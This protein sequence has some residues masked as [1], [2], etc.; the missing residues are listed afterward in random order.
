M[1][2][3]FQ[4]FR[5]LNSTLRSRTQ[6][7]VSIQRKVRCIHALM[8]FVFV[9]CVV[10]LP[11]VLRRFARVGDASKTA[12]GPVLEPVAGGELED[13]GA[14]DPCKLSSSRRACLFL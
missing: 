10:L 2:T 6:R 8:S 11:P 1:R 4:P 9:V 3:I 5:A 7:P 14:L 13:T 12:V